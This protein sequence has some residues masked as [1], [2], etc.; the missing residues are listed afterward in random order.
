MH[1]AAAASSE[2]GS[3]HASAPRA[4]TERAATA[5]TLA[6]FLGCDLFPH[7]GKNLHLAD[8]GRDQG[9][10]VVRAVGAR[11]EEARDQDETLLERHPGDFH[12]QLPAEVGINLPGDL[13]RERRVEHAS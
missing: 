13:P 5:L 10:V 3:A 2:T 12:W 6:I 4:R 7:T 11:V 8:F 1:G 9:R